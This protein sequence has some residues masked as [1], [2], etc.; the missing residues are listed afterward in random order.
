ML[1]PQAVPPQ[2]DELSRGQRRWSQS[3]HCA[4]APPGHAA[5][6]AW[7]EHRAASAAVLQA[8]PA[9]LAQLQALPRRVAPSGRALQLRA[10]RARVFPPPHPLSCH[11]FDSPRKFAANPCPAKSR[12]LHQFPSARASCACPS[13][14]LSPDPLTYYPNHISSAGVRPRIPSPMARQYLTAVKKASR[15]MVVPLSPSTMKRN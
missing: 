15:V 12:W 6:P 5:L 9:R 11:A 13:S 1:S 14:W 8:S 4:G 7:P 10:F 3:D 2:Q